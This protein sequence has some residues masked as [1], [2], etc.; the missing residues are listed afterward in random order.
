MYVPHTHSYDSL[1]I[2]DAPRSKRP[3]AYDST[4][5]ANASAHTYDSVDPS[6]FVGKNATY[7]SVPVATDSDAAAAQLPQKKPVSTPPSEA[8]SDFG[9][10]NERY[11]PSHIER[12]VSAR[13]GGNGVGGNEVVKKPGRSVVAALYEKI[14]PADGMPHC[15][16]SEYVHLLAVILVQLH[17]STHLLTAY[18]DWNARFQSI[19]EMSERTQE[20]TNSKYQA[21]AKLSVGF[22]GNGQDLRQGYHRGAFAAE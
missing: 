9:V 21:L 6:E 1:E 8:S 19:L 20:D 17:F 18:V 14:D 15:I 2:S 16:L 22:R 10:F 3:D 12:S 7:D 5:P 4:Q 11:V 13:I